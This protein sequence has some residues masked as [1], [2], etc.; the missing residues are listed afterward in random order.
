MSY[1]YMSYMCVC[2]KY[3]HACTFLRIYRH[4]MQFGMFQ[5]FKAH[6]SISYYIPYHDMLSFIMLCYD[7]LCYAILYFTLLCYALLYYN[8]C[9]KNCMLHI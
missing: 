2:Q 5:A 9:C 1:I 4:S 8:I 3:T 7:M 6:R